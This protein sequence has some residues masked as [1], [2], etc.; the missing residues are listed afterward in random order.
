M[1]LPTYA[2]QRE[3]YWLDAPVVGG[4]ALGLGL[5]TSDH[6]LLG[7]SVPLADGNGLILTGRLS[8][9]THPWLADHAVMGT[10]LLPGTA[11]VE[12]ALHAGEQVG[13]DQIIDLTLES[14]LV[15]PENG[16]V[17]L[18]LSVGSP[19]VDGTREIAV[20]S[21]PDGDGA[22]W[23]RHATGTLA[24]GEP[25]VP[26]GTDGTWPPAGALAV[27]TSDLYTRLNGQGYEYGSAF[28]GV[29]AVWRDGAD[30]YAEVRL[31][32]DQEADADLFGLHPALFDAVLHPLLPDDH[33]SDGAR[34]RL[35]FAWS[36]ARLHAVGASEL[37]VRLTFSG[38]ETVS[39]LAT[40]TTGAPV[41]SLDSLVLRAVSPEQLSP[42]GQDARD[43]LY[44]VVWTPTALS[45]TDDAVVHQDLDTV[46][47]D[48]EVPE[49]VVLRCA[50]DGDPAPGSVRA[51][52][53]ATLRA[54]QGFLSDERFADSR[55]VV[56]TR[57][58]T[59]AMPGEGG[60]DL[61]QAAVWGLI[62]TAQT[63][64]PDRIVLVD[65]DTDTDGGS[66]AVPAVLATGEPQIALRGGGALVPRLAR[67]SGTESQP[68]LFHETGTVVVTGGT[69]TLGG[70]VAR[71]LVVGHGVR[72]LV[73]TSRRGMESEGAAEL[74][75]ELTGLGARVRI[76]ACDAAD[77]D[78]L[79]ALLGEVPEEY[80][81]TGVVHC[82][83]VLDDA[84]FTA[85]T[86]EQM[87]SVL[88]PKVDAAWNLHELTRDLDLSAFVLFSSVTATM[89][90]AGQANYTAANAYLDALAESRDA[91]GLPATSL[92]WGLWA[93]SSGM[94]GHLSDAD[95]ARMART[96]VAPMSNAEGL[97]LFDAAL[98]TEHPVLVP[99]RLNTA[100]LRNLAGVGA[101]PRLFQGLV[102]APR[103]SA[104][105]A[106]TAD[107]TWARRLGTMP[108]EERHAVLVE[109]VR[110]NTGA[111]LGHG[112]DA[113]IDVDRAFR[114][115]GF[116]SLT[117]VELRNRINRETGLR[118]PATL[119]FDYPTPAALVDHLLTE[120]TG[121]TAAAAS[122][123]LVA[124]STGN[125]DEPIAIVAMSC[126]F[127]GGVRSPEDLWRLVVEGR[128]AVSEFPTNRG[129]NLEEL[130]HPDPD[131]TGTSY[132]R[133]GGFLHDADHFDA[134]F[135]GI[136][137]R[138]AMAT[139]PQQRLLLH[140]AWEAFERAGIDPT[141]LKGSDTGVFAG[142]MYD[143]YASRLH[144][145]PDGFEG[146]LLT[147][148]TTSV[149]SGRVSYTFGLEGPAVTVDTA[150]SSALTAMH[151]AAQSLRQGESSLALAGG[152][153]LMATPNT[154]VEFS[155]QR[156][157]SPDGRCRSFAE[158]TDG[159]GWGE[160][161][162]LVLLERLSDAQRNGHP[163]LAVMRGS[164]VNQ[165]GA[166]NG[167]TA[168][169]G[170]SQ[171]R[172]IRQA[173]ANAKLGPGDVDAVEAHGTGTRLGD[174]IEAQALLATYGQGRA[175]D[176]PLWLG[177]VKSNIGHTQA[178]A[179]A[180]GV[181]KM[182]MAMRH[183][184]LPRTLHVDE[185]TR[186]VDWEAGAVELLMEGVDWPEVDRPRRAAVSSFGVSGTNAHVVLEQAPAVESVSGVVT[187][188]DP[189]DAVVAWPVSAR[190]E[191]ALRGQAARLAGFVREHGADAEFSLAGVGRALVSTRAVF[192][193]RAV[194]IGQDLSELVDGLDAL[195]R[196]EPAAQVVWGTSRGAGR[197][198]FVFP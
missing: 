108:E 177:S 117:A 166:S 72:S 153:A 130:Y 20:H 185:P 28:Q 71:H 133:H 30:I 15:L 63:E 92:A 49:A 186:K 139:D 138:E 114:D 198:V 37:R 83:G 33:G 144:R 149:A 1:D 26:P 6:P 44:H 119:V 54:V 162:G 51:T 181:I 4:S 27:P 55:L 168:P 21:L 95:I 77:R 66:V 196:G 52:V 80:P 42:R 9:A 123:A 38:T 178:A 121:T 170:P 152:V 163:V 35:P 16:G 171:Q 118:L 182:V 100:A 81:L 85:L 39:V 105:S 112:G 127:P 173:L 129:W 110:S 175:E 190:G 104:A 184:H 75:A 57:G 125:D 65:T 142:V 158:G 191:A 61:A 78:A 3:R 157:L 147:G 176:R 50:G 62:R 135:F 79:A 43:S 106:D 122:S 90:N 69:G 47:P 14:P 167:L 88:R 32:A 111:V 58:A 36:G 146:Y 188:E 172:V 7:A 76:A 64:N 22:E 134:E 180:A 179:G 74:E 2:F 41:I 145:A 193:H 8:L 165:D 126:R 86:P 131:H 161:V 140:T 84:T 94:T 67:V 124:A 68:A 45:E 53:D 169:N 102:R 141:S 155:R 25:S 148:N 82:A 31:D 192:D 87:G 120:L 89:G 194:V 29:R 109:L 60:P 101:L 40:D 113:S 34:P 91:E 164:A 59:S 99:A 13:C 151:L 11:F 143:D 187:E 12:L 24:P 189:E 136:S 154:F 197:T 137:P 70:L 128:D 17:R 98:A 73:L 18:Q 160:G 10:V 5:A 132:T 156:G 46:A 93:E 183:G 159:T 19:T 195:T 96:G 174:P 107:Q 150:C 48:S 56:L 103:R 97:A 116:D 115:L 23:T